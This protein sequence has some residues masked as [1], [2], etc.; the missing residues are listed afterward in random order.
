[1]ETPAMG[2]LIQFTRGKFYLAVL[3]TSFVLFTA[4]VA[5]YAKA[6]DPAEPSGPKPDP[7][8]VATGD[9]SSAVDAGGASFVVAEPTDTSA[10][11]YAANK[12]A[13]DEYQAAAAKEPL[14]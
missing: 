9:R 5:N 12:K 13:Y 3:A 10:P 7:A 11:D 6:E 14:A 1:M 2:R 4:A 8:G